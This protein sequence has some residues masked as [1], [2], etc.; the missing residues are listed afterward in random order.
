MNS[1][2]EAIKDGIQFWPIPET[3]APEAAFGL[4]EDAY[5]NRR[6][7]PAVPREYINAASDLFFNGGK[8]PNLAPGVDRREAAR[9][10]RALLCSF[11]PSHESKEATA[12]YALWV[13]STPEIV[14]VTT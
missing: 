9:R 10:L 11:A 2:P 7:L 3:S 6:S 1:K 5:F 8:L 14:Q 4:K 12:A 13:W